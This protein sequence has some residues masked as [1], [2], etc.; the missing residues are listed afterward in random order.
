MSVN[1]WW[2]GRLVC[3]NDSLFQEVLRMDSLESCP[4]KN[5]NNRSMDTSERGSTRRSQQRT[6]ARHLQPSHTHGVHAAIDVNVFARHAAG[7][8]TDEK[9]S[10]PAN[11]LPRDVSTQRRLSGHAVEH[12][13]NAPHR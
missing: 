9:H 3:V 4:T 8:I 1:W 11:V 10:G 7:E 5:R 12:V 2:R 6:G 13:H